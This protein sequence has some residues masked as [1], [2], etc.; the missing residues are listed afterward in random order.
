MARSLLGKSIGIL[1]VTL[2]DISNIL[3]FKYNPHPNRIGTTDLPL[4]WD[5]IL[6]ILHGPLFTIDFNFWEIITSLHDRR[7]GKNNKLDQ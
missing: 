4:N 7:L 3:A 5:G 2:I 1:L 6:G